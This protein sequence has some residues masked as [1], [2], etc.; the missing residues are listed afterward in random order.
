M[1]SAQL[2]GTVPATTPG[3]YAV[4]LVRILA[5]LMLAIAACMVVAG[6]LPVLF[7]WHSY[8]VLSGSM[9]PSLRTGDV[10]IAAPAHPGD[11]V[12]GRIVVF[13]EPGSPERLIVHRVH[14]PNPDGT[15][16]TKGDANPVADTARVRP[17]DVRGLVRL[18]LPMIALPISWWQTGAWPPLVAS[19]VL[20]VGLIII[21]TE[22]PDPGRRAESVPR[23]PP[24]H[25]W[26]AHHRRSAGPRRGRSGRAGPSTAYRWC[27]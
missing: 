19:A 18:R 13:R 3:R 17:D 26:V 7:G 1:G 16:V 9:T 20:L 10:V 14:A 27:R 6:L 4:G 25:R 21:A 8:V 23:S 22:L 15:L 5:R 2:T 12:P 24:R 11:A